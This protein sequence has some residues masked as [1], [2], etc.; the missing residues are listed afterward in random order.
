MTA[1]S[2]FLLPPPTPLDGKG[3]GEVERPPPAVCGGLSPLSSPVYQIFQ[4]SYFTSGCSIGGTQ[5][6]QML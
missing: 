3:G 1:F 5:H 6:Q 2:L 4:L